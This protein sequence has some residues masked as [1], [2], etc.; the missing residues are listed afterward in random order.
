MTSVTVEKIVNGRHEATFS[1]PAFFLGMA[2]FMLPQAA[3]HA[4]CEKGMDVRG[5]VL[6]GKRGIPYT[7]S[8]NLVEQGVSKTVIVSVR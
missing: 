5:M 1:F 2:S 4:L 3:L 8:V 7:A 6:A